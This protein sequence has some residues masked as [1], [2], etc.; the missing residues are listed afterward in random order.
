MNTISLRER[1]VGTAELVSD[2]AEPLLNTERGGVNTTEQTAGWRRVDA[3]PGSK[4]Q[5]DTLNCYGQRTVR[6]RSAEP[7]ALAVKSRTWIMTITRN[8]HEG[9]CVRS[10]IQGWDCFRIRQ[11]YWSKQS[12]ICG[13]SGLSR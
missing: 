12:L 3:T 7:L 8:W 13:A 4:T 11:S 9:F 1:P 2:V 6:V 10:V 5:S